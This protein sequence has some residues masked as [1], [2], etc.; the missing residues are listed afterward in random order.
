[1]RFPAAKLL[2]INILS[3]I[4]VSACTSNKNE[5]SSVE[6]QGKK[7]DEAGEVREQLTDVI[8]QMPSPSQV[9]FLLEATGATFNESFVNPSSK[10]ASYTVSNNK[11]ALNLGVYASDIAYLASY[12]KAQEALTYMQACSNLGENIGL[13]ATM[14]LE[15]VKRFERNLSSKDSLAKIVDEA[16]GNADNFLREGDRGTVAALML[17]GI[18]IEGLYIS[19]QIIESLPQASVSDQSSVVNQLLKEIVGQKEAMS[20]LIDILNGVETE[21]WVEG[22]V[23]SLEQLRDNFEAV[24]ASDNSDGTNTVLAS[25]SFK[26]MSKQIAVVRNT[27]TY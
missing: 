2:L 19:T 8:Y 21:D 5:S 17:A 9:P 13:Q 20:T 1:M 16:I 10:A 24:E 22:L 11:S 7:F 23:N 15:V 26:R 18:Y 6:E 4:L 12:E 3:V 14:D 27:V 25:N